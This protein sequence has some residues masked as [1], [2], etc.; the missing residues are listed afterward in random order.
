MKMSKS[1]LIIA[2]TYL[3]LVASVLAM[4]ALFVSDPPRLSVDDIA[5]AFFY[6][7]FLMMLSQLPLVLFVMA[8]EIDDA[9]Q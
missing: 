7:T 9:R 4:A 6:T 3:S 8:K 5:S 2:I 1:K